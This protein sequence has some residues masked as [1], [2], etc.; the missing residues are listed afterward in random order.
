MPTR[1]NSHVVADKAIADVTRIWI[2]LGCACDPVASD[3][4]EDLI[5]QPSC[6][7][8]MDPFR[9]LVQVR[10]ATSLE[11]YRRKNGRYTLRV[12]LESFYKWARSS[13]LT[14]VVLWDTSGQTGLWSAPQDGYDNWR[15]FCGAAKPSKITFAPSN[16][17]DVLAAS[18]IIWKARIRYFK[19]L[20]VA[21]QAEQP[22]FIKEKRAAAAKAHKKKDTKQADLLALELLILLGMVDQKFY[23]NP[24]VALVARFK[25]AELRAIATPSPLIDH[26]GMMWTLIV[27]IQAFTNEGTPGVLLEAC[28]RMLMKIVR[29]YGVR[30]WKQPA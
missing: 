24:E 28:G 29:K 22:T 10:G 15:F 17:F 6:R 23:F 12:R 16:G 11:R 9:I 21:A 25:A 19:N 18:K 5:V 2:E 3:Y 26:A 8:R 20:I 4:G 30:C 27:R 1:P 14:I 7:G 13:D